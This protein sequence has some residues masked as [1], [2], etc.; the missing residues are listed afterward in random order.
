[1]RQSVGDHVKHNPYFAGFPRGVPD[2]TDFWIECILEFYINDNPVYGRPGHTFEEMV[3]LQ[4][5]LRLKKDVR[6]KVVD[7]GG[8]LD[9]ELQALFASLAGSTVPLNVEDRALLAALFAHGCTADVP[10]RIRENKAIL[11][12]LRLQREQPVE[13]DTVVDVLR[14]ACALSD[15]DVTL[16]TPTKFRSFSRRI[17]RQLV[18]TLDQLIARDERKIDD[19][20]NYKERFKRLAEKLHPREHTRCVHAARLFDFTGG[21]SDVATF[22][23]RA[24]ESVVAGRQSGHFQQAVGVLAERPGM[25]LKHVDLILRA[26]DR[27]SA[28]GLLRA[29]EARVEKISGRNLLNLDQHL[30]NRASP[31]ASRIFVNRHGRGH[32]SPQ[33]CPRCRRRRSRRWRRPSS[34]KPSHP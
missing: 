17:R 6:L 33:D 24:H 4:S 10:V 16:A 29:F 7:L 9:A 28:D 32:A 20:S 11:N 1:M 30:A 31:Q 26:G 18:E 3:E 13:V 2:T 25:L 22:N 15:G 21:K 34:R 19:A 27:G 8:P 23:R 12:A 14:M 5:A